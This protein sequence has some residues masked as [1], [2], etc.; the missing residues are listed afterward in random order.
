MNEKKNTFDVLLEPCKAYLDKESSKID[1]KTNSK[2]LFFA[3]FFK[4]IVFAVV[5]QVLEV[6]VEKLINQDI[7]KK[8]MVDKTLLKADLMDTFRK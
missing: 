8:N 4:I 3:N 1:Q 7:Q 6:N 5:I 2:K